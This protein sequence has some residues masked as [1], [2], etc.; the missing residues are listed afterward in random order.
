MSTQTLPSARPPLKPWPVPELAEELS[1]SARHLWRLIAEK[2]IKS[3]RIGHR[4]L[5]P[6]AEA[7]KILREGV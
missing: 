3:I 1:C 5:V 2:K 4:V 6:A 7:E